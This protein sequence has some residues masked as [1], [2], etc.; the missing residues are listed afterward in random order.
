MKVTI[1][2]K[3]KDVVLAGLSHCLYAYG[4]IIT[5]IFFQCSHP[6][7]FDELFKKIGLID[8][9]DQ[10]E[11]LRERYNSIKSIFEQLDKMEI[12]DGRAR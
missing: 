7:I 3:D 1:D 10:I 4:Q 9:D 2:I 5:A 6:D 11:Y 12:E 8:L